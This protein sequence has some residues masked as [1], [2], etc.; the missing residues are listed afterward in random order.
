MDNPLSLPVKASRNYFADTGNSLG[1]RIAA[2]M[3]VAR[4]NRAKVIQP[5]DDLSTP[6]VKQSDIQ[7]TS[8]GNIVKADIK[9]L[10]GLLR[11]LLDLRNAPERDSYGILRLDDRVFHRA[12]SLLIDASIDLAKEYGTEIVPYGC[13]TT[14]VDG[15]LR[16][17]WVRDNT[18]VHLVLP[19]ASPDEKEYIF[20]QVGPKHGME[21]S[22][23]SK[24]LARYLSLINKDS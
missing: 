18:N 21:W 13:A 15:G 19:V 6:S 16:L 3:S 14:D 1:Y 23:T 5:S 2:G 9:H 20:H 7:S 11:Q 4:P 8:R 22:V 17:E 10:S 24:S 12:A